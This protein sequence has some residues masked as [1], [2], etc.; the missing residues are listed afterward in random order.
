LIRSEPNFQE[1][2][3]ASAEHP[4]NRAKQQPQRVHHVMLLQHTACGREESIRYFNKA[5]KK[6]PDYYEAYYQRCGAK[7]PRPE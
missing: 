4:Q 1:A 6:Y 2:E 3:H 5:I 7:A